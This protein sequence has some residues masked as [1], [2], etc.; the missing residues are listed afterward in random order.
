MACILQQN[1][2]RICLQA[3]KRILLSVA[4]KRTLG[5]YEVVERIGRGGMAEVY[6]GY[7]AA[8]DR[9]VAIKLLHPFLADDPEFKDRFEKEAKNVAKLRH[10]NIVQVFDFEHDNNGES[11][12][13]VME[14]INGPTLKDLLQEKSVIAQR[15]SIHEASRIIADTSNALAYAHKRGMI[16]RDIKPANIMLDEDERVVLTDFGIAKIV[17][18]GNFTASGGMVGTPAYMAPEQGLGEAGDERS[19]IYS[20][21]VM[22]YQMVTGELP[23]DADTPLAIILKHVNDEIPDPREYV[24]DLP[25]WLVDTIY[26]CLSKEPEK[27]YQSATTLLNNIRQGVKQG[28]RLTPII[29][30]S[31][32]NSSVELLSSQLEGTDVRRS[33]PTGRIVIPE[34]ATGR[35]PAIRPEDLKRPSDELKSNEITA[36]VPSPNNPDTV[37]ANRGRSARLLAALLILVLLL[38]GFALL[39]QEGGPFSGLFADPTNT[40][41]PVVVFTDDTATATPQETPSITPTASDTP[42][43]T[44]TPSET[45]TYTPTETYTY[46][47]SYTPSETPSPTATFTETPDP[48][49]T[50]AILLTETQIALSNREQTLESAQTATQDAITFATQTV[51]AAG[52][53]T[54]DART[55]ATQTQRAVRTATQEA[56][57]LAT[58]SAIPAT[59]NPLEALT[60]CERDYVL[61]S[62]EDLSI[63]PLLS[64]AL[65]PRLVRA[66]TD[67]SLTIELENASTCDWPAAEGR[68]EL[69][70]VPDTS[71]LDIDYEQLSAVCGNAQ[72]AQPV[73]TDVNFTKPVRPRIVVPEAEY[74]RDTVLTLDIEMGAPNARGCYFGAWQLQF[75][76]FERLPIGEPIVFAIQ[77]F[78]GS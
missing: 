77:V 37:R 76:D 52:T 47:P 68:L 30:T 41:V 55:F 38:G 69:V 51:S 67:F 15:F 10:P 63:P 64:D 9:Y 78:G 1:H 12:Y 53:A 57:A 2:G 61:L 72:P 58:A 18:G 6:R 8:L 16:H 23:F 45:P 33:D 32:T 20:L 73:F 70:F 5:K 40:A 44:A 66:N 39:S 42:T 21:G 74:P 14:L 43:A 54:Q 4:T 35:F 48:T 65:N 3:F 24:P 46:T 31:T 49:E 62:P 56:I 60:A 28:T 34:H 7:H 17:T 50:A 25:A 36:T 71:D 19:D 27:R 29:D 75:T 13:M 26:T 11:Y 22:L 59:L